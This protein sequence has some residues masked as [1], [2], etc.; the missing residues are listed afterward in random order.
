MYGWYIAFKCISTQIFSRVVVVMN[1]NALVSMLAF[2]LELNPKSTGSAVN[3]SKQ[4]LATSFD[5]DT[6]DATSTSRFFPCHLLS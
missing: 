6:R 5:F 2:F 3:Q 4:F 1:W